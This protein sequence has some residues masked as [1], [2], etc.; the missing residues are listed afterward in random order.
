MPDIAMCAS[1][2]CPLKY[3]CYRFMAEP[4]PY[5]QSYIERDPETCK[6]Y[7]PMNWKPEQQKESPKDGK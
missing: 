2:T 3:N 1:A 5:R 4:N 7:W 6:E